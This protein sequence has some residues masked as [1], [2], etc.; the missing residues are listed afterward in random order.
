MPSV[1]G[2]NFGPAASPPSS[3]FLAL[4]T[5]PDGGIHDSI[6]GDIAVQYNGYLYVGY[7]DDSGNVVVS[8][9]QESA[10]PSDPA[11]TVTIQSGWAKDI[12]NSPSLLVEASTHKLW[13]A[14]CQHDG[15][16][17]Y[18]R[19]STTSLA[20]DPTLGDGFGSAAGLNS[21]LGDWGDF[22]YPILLQLTGEASSPVYLF[23]RTAHGNGRLMYSKCTD[24]GS[25]WPA[26]YYC[27]VGAGSNFPYW[28]VGATSTTRFDVFIT[29]G[30]DFGGGE[31]G[32][33]MY[34]F[35]YSGGSFYQT[36]GTLI[37]AENTGVAAVS[38]PTYATL[39]LDNTD[40]NV[41]RACGVAWGSSAPAGGLWQ[42]ID[43][44][45][46]RVLSARWRS[47]AWQVDTVLDNIPRL[48]GN[49]ALPSGRMDPTDPDV[50]VVAKAVG[51]HVEMFRLTT[52]DDGATWASEALTTVSTL[53]NFLPAMVR[54][55]SGVQALWPAGTYTNDYSFSLGFRGI[56]P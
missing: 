6:G 24:G 13:V 12:H 50:C 20:T 45:T 9:W 10:L 25:T 48:G 44:S 5:A 34:H 39:V 21:Q 47:G 32:E 30:I 22:T 17:L 8:V 49:Y 4:A 36:D 40:G 52:A 16:D 7:V 27:C 23:W 43:G 2:L 38:D 51:S 41:T 14:F 19:I 37:G 46:N 55:A 53:D 29:D 42:R 15:S 35:Y 1:A 3:G 31:A 18:L 56:A 26:L 11:A 54:N 33:S 28:S